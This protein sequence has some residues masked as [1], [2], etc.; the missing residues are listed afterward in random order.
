[1]IFKKK[2]KEDNTITRKENTVLNDKPRIVIGPDGN[3]ISINNDILGWVRMKRDDD[4]PKVV[5]LKQDT[6]KMM[7]EYILEE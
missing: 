5:H 7:V 4:I 3:F 2:K 1:M 6:P